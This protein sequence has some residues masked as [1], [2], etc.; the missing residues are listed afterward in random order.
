MLYFGV[1]QEV[2]IDMTPLKPDMRTS[3]I[4]E[5]ICHCGIP[6]AAIENGKEK[7]IF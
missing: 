3:L 5:C 4:S 7:E 2:T 6:E 1:E